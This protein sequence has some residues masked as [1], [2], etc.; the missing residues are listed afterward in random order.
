[1]AVEDILVTHAGLTQHRWDAVGRPMSAS[2][3]ADAINA[4]L[5]TDPEA[6]FQAGWMLAGNSAVDADPGVTWTHTTR[7]LYPGWQRA[8]AVPFGQVHGHLSAFNWNNNRWDHLTPTELRRTATIDRDSRHLTVDIGGKP[9]TGIDPGLGPHSPRG[10]VPFVLGR[11]IQRPTF[12]ATSRV[13]AM[14]NTLL[15]GGADY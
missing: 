15:D 7:E 8:K 12:G 11:L 4:E 6:A 10:L 9:F 13:A 2:G 3:A 1:M 5:P 14:V